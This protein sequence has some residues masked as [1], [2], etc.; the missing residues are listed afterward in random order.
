MNIKNREYVCWQLKDGSFVLGNASLE[1][2]IVY[3]S[4]VAAER[5]DYLKDGALET[6]NTIIS[7]LV[8]EVGRLEHLLSEC[9]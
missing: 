4:R 9:R 1:E 7:D 6:A 3:L 8:A 5:K 2:T